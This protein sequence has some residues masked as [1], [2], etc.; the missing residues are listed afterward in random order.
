MR[1][2]RSKQ[3]SREKRVAK[4]LPFDS[5]KRADSLREFEM[6]KVNYRILVFVQNAKMFN[7]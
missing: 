7:S 5:L 6:L 4:I 3:G 2:T 1:N